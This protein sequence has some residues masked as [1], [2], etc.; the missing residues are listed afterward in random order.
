MEM[1]SNSV[2]ENYFYWAKDEPKSVESFRKGKPVHK[3]P[4]VAYQ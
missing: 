1:Q 2:F 4:K 3:I